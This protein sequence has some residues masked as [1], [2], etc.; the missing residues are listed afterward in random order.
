MKEFA[1]NQENKSLKITDRILA[2][3]GK[4]FHVWEAKA[5]HITTLSLIDKKRSLEIVV[6]ILGKEDVFT[7]TFQKEIYVQVKE[8]FTK[9]L[10][11]VKVKNR[12]RSSQLQKPLVF[13]GLFALITGILVYKSRQIENAEE[14]VEGDGEIGIFDKLCDFL[15][16]YLG[17]EGILIGG[18]F[19]IVICALF[20]LKLFL[21]PKKGA[22]VRFKY[23]DQIMN[24][25]PDS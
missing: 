15:T 17:S 7:V 4:D 3:S 22:I 13:A 19:F 16:E 9:Q 10:R 18:G 1:T 6:K 24:F 5:E 23:G 2:L 20:A 21:I 14:I 25:T 11:N 8:Y 12:T